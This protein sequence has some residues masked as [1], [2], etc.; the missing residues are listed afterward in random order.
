MNGKSSDLTILMATYEGEEFLA[1]QI[2]SFANQVGTSIRLVVSDDSQSNRTR[3]ALGRLTHGIANIDLHYS[4]GPKK[5]FA[6]NFRALLLNALPETEFYAFSDQDDIW[7]ADKSQ[8]SLEWLRQQPSDVPALYCGRTRMIDRDG[9]DI[10]RLSPLFAHPP[11]FENALVQ[12]IAG[13]NTMT[14]NRVAFDIL[15]RSLAKGAPV[16]H[17]W[18]AYIM[19]SGSGGIVKYDPEPLTLYRQHG[20]NLIGE[21]RSYF[22]RLTRLRMVWDGTWGRWQDQHLALLDDNLGQLT[23]EAHA[24]LQSFKSA[25]ARSHFERLNWLR[26]SGVWR[27]TKAGTASLYLAS[28]MGRL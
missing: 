13:G 7:V 12:S 19:V 25:R 14:M 4:E 17:D 9:R 3:K 26:K 16:S 18:W 10:G 20:G 6:E 11:A 5:G 22:A 28:L 21:N 27:Q 24:A 23:A 2:E 1:P 8:R 15:R